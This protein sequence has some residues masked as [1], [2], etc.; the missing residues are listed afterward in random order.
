MDGEEKIPEEGPSYVII[1]TCI[2]FFGGGG[3]AWHRQVEWQKQCWGAA[4][5]L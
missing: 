4:S 2:F 3:Y 1:I 5:E